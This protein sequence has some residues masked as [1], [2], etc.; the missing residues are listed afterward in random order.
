MNANTD[1]ELRKFVAPELVYGAEAPGSSNRG[2]RV[3]SK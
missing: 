2:E 1:I 3:I